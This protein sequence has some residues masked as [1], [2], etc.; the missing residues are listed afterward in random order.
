MQINLIIQKEGK[1]TFSQILKEKLK[2]SKKLYVFSGMLK[3][4]GFQII[5]EELLDTK[6]KSFFVIGVDKKNTTKT[7][8]ESMLKLT[9][10]CY[11]YINNSEIEYNANFVIIE[12]AKEAYIYSSSSNFSESGMVDNLSE[13]LEVKFDLLDT[14]DKDEY[15]LKLKEFLKISEDDKFSKLDKNVIEN[16]VNDKEIFSTRQY[17]HNVISISE[18]LGKKEENNNMLSNGTEY[19]ENAKL[20]KIDLSGVD[21]D[22]EIPD[23]DISEVEKTEEKQKNKKEK[24]DKNIDNDIVFETFED[25]NVSENGK[26]NLEQI[27]VQEEQNDLNNMYDEELEKLDFNEDETIDINDLLFTKAKVKL[28]KKE[29]K[30][31]QK[32]DESILEV[33]KLNL[34][35]VSNLILEL[36]Q[37]PSKGQDL[38]N[39]KVPNYIKQMIPEFF[40]FN[41]NSRNESI[42]GS[43]YKLRDVEIEIVNAKTSEKFTDRKAKLMIKQGQTYTTFN[44][45]ALENVEYNE[46]DI[47]RIIKLSSDIYHIEIIPKELN[48]Y[49]IWSKVCNQT[50][51]STTRKYGMM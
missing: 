13:F 51:K 12:N 47:V 7:M 40:E 20:P 14:K 38:K 50:M 17:N 30:E 19:N 15:K 24:V 18:L 8:L 31:E 49:K 33:K 32:E 35:N 48:E 46:G 44:T 23:I 22:I 9:H 41:E 6:I 29:K 2:D 21:I 42:N 43:M 37:R 34:N 5:E 28:T 10:D 4:S 25:N 16:L 45:P 39:I 3:E 26:K 1:N 11:F 27:E 36:P